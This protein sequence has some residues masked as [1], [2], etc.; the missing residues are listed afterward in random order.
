MDIDRLL[1]SDIHVKVISFFHENQASIDTPRGVATWIG[2]DRAV[3]KSALEDL[4]NAHILVA[5]R[6]TSTTGYSYTSDEKIISKIAKV[7]KKRKPA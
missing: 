7:L 6:A 2:E 4:V 3:T 5:H 1:Q